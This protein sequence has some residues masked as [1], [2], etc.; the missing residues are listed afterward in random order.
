MTCRIVPLYLHTALMAVATIQHGQVVSNF[1][2]VLLCSL[3]RLSN[4]TLF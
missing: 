4:A 1:G 3:L 2:N